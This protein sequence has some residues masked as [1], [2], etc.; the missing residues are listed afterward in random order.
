MKL[1]LCKLN[2]KVIISKLNI[3]NRDYLSRLYSLGFN[4]GVHVKVEFSLKNKKAIIVSINAR[5]VI[6]SSEIADLIEVDYA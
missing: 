6:L 4:K 1:T 3:D 2:K 5:A